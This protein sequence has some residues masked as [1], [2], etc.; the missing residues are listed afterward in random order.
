MPPA[1]GNSAKYAKA[2]DA[3][4]AIIWLILVQPLLFGAIGVEIDFRVI[5]GALITKTV[6]MLALGGSLPCRPR[7]PCWVA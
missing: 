7:V 3:K 6:I 1:A 5:A 2:C 4:L